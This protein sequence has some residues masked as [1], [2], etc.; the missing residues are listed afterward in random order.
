MAKYSFYTVLAAAIIA[1][2]YVTMDEPAVTTT[3][4]DCINSPQLVTPPSA[5]DCQKVEAASQDTGISWPAWLIGTDSIQFH[6][7]DLL[8]LLFSSSAADTAASSSSSSTSL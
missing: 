1:L 4:R 2:L 7:L 3:E 5:S 8:E 6:Y